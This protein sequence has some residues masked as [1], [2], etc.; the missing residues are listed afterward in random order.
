MRRRWREMPGKGGA[1]STCCLTMV[2]L[3][4]GGISSCPTTTSAATGNVCAVRRLPAEQ[5]ERAQI[6]DSALVGSGQR[7]H[8]VNVLAPPIR[9]SGGAH[10][11]ARDLHLDL[12]LLNATAEDLRTPARR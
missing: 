11:C 10:P 3:M 9:C 4:T 5:P 8:W 7:A 1:D 12:D 6:A 2:L